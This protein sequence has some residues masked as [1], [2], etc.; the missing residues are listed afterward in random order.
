MLHRALFGS[1]ERFFGVLLE[2][3]AGNFP[4]WLAPV[5]VRVLPVV[6]GPRGVRRRG[7]RR[8]LA[9]G[10]RPR[11]HRRTPTTGSASASAPSK[12]EKIPYILVVGDDDVADRHGRRQPAGG[13]EPSSAASTSTTFI[14]R[15]TD[16]VAEQP[17]ARRPD[18]PERADR[19]SN[20][21]GT[22][23]GRPTS[24]RP[25][26][27]RR[28]GEGSVFTSIL[29]SGLVRRRDQHRPPRRARAS[30]SSTPSRTAPGTCWCCRTARSPTSR[31]STPDETAELWATVTDAVRAV[32]TAYRPE[33]VNV[34]INLGRPA[35]GSGERAPARA[36][37]AAL[38]RR[39]QLHDGRRQHADAARAAGRHG[40]QDPGRLA[41]S[42]VGSRQRWTADLRRRRRRHSRRAARRSRRRASSSG[43][44]SSPT[45]RGVAS[46]G[47]I[48]LVLAAV[49]L[50]AVPAGRPNR[51]SSTTASRGRR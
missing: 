25:A 16:E 50:V 49:C 11:R 14:A 6:D 42:R 27:A 48:Y 12:L 51:C 32:K 17:N 1:V 13:G 26:T 35:G 43:P 45:T 37:R 19:C 33:G 28:R 21:S 36:R 23:G 40:R 34:G 30:R 3:Y 4:T 2:H 9:R 10:R 44:T 38:D 5:Q 39:R 24:A 22:A 47:A 18:A 8:P 15:F 31:S 46:P 41:A 20:G 7:G 29:S